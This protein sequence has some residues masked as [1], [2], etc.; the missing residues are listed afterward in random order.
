VT[1]QP[2]SNAAPD[3]RERIIAAA[4]ELES[5][6]SW[7]HLTLK[8][9]AKALDLHYTALYYHFKSMDDL[10]AA[11]VE[12]L[13]R[14]RSQHLAQARDAGASAFDQLIAFIKLELHQPPTRLLT[15]AA[16][17]RIGGEP[18]HRARHAIR[19]HADE[20]GAL[21]QSGIDDGSIRLCDPDTVSRMIN[22]IM[23][24]YAHQHEQLFERAHFDADFLTQ[25]V[26][27][28]VAN[29]IMAPGF[30]PALLGNG[31]AAPIRPLA[32]S[33]S[34]LEKIVSTL[35][36]QF[37]RHGYRGT[38]IPEVAKSIGLSKT[39]FYKYAASKEEL[40]YLCV[41]HSMRLIAESRQLAVA[42]TDNPLAAL[43]HLVYYDRFLNA[44][45]PGPY[46][47]VGLYDS[48][49]SEHAEVARDF[50]LVRRWETISLLEQCA[51]AGLTRNFDARAVQPMVW[52]IGI[53]LQSDG[54]TH[55]YQDEVTQFILQGIAA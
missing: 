17:R 6:G 50:D 16:S 40:L 1:A 44:N 10:R 15:T 8:G 14:Q 5:H 55:G 34:N 36:D 43:L 27:D 11:L 9:L 31:P 52:G 25:T 51:V 21:I 46:V 38:S 22:H 24:R 35:S 20:L 33:S 53:P 29:G 49:S 47:N 3:T 13:A 41:Q 19:A 42:V 26:V 12:Y 37:N 48:L 54:H 32:S 23:G 18:G 7:A 45:P 39:S 2:T 4:L 30:D 28:F